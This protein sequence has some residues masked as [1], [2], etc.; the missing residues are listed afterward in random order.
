MNNPF[1]HLPAQVSSYIRITFVENTYPDFPQRFPSLF[2]SFWFR[3]RQVVEIVG[4]L[5]NIIMNNAKDTPPITQ[6]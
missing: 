3:F 1:M 6:A 4:R 5:I 2:F